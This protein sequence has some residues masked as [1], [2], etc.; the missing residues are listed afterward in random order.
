MVSLLPVLQGCLEPHMCLPY[1]AHRAY[2][3]Q[4]CMDSLY[5]STVSLLFPGFFK[6]VISIDP[7]QHNHIL[8][9]N[10]GISLVIDVNAS[11]YSLSQIGL[12]CTIDISHQCMFLVDLFS[13]HKD[14]FG[15]KL[16][17][18]LKFWLIY[19]K[20]DDIRRATSFKYN[21]FLTLNLI[22]HLGQGNHVVWKFTDI[23]ELKQWLLNPLAVSFFFV[24]QM[25]W[26]Y[27]WVY[28]KHTNWPQ[29]SVFCKPL[30]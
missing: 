23:T 26:W 14:P 15:L 28:M 24:L 18:R 13:Q 9:I 10:M 22:F 8:S 30:I 4:M 11:V 29:K 17:R 3:S 25:E 2:K 19:K 6:S 5:C 16:V 20:N 27:F 12:D 7:V 21:F 1:P